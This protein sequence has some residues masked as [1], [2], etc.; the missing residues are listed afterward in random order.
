M[1][2]YINNSIKFYIEELAGK[3]STPGGGSAAALV[4]S[5][6]VGLINMVG[7]FSVG[8]TGS[9]DDEEK[10]QELL[11]SAAEF[12]QA[13]MFLIDED[14]K[15]YSRLAEAYKMPRQTEQDKQRRKKAIS[16]GAELSLDTS[17]SICTHVYKALELLPFLIE[18]GNENLYSD[19]KSSFSFLEAAFY[20]AFFTVTENLKLVEDKSK[21]EQTTKDLNFYKGEFKKVKA[22]L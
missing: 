8:K 21:I 1:I 15:S 13:L 20:S 17:F 3:K 2:M 6:G 11:V 4:G 14:V 5:L 18:K 7:N 19:I 16:E 9:G 12:R 10:M 22:N